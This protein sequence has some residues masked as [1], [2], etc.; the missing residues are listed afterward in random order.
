MRVQ[1]GLLLSAGLI[2]A[3]PVFA[4]KPDAGKFILQIQGTQIGTTT[5]KTDKEGGTTFDQDINLG[6][7]KA[8]VHAVITATGGKISKVTYEATPGGKYSLNV[9]GAKSTVS[10]NGAKEKP[11]KLADKIYLF[12]NFAPHVL[13]GLLRAY[14]SKKGG[15]QKLDC[16][17]LNNAVPMKVNVTS[18]GTKPR[19][20]GGKMVSTT[21]YVLSIAGGAGTVEI[22]VVI[23]SDFR[24]LMWNVVAQ[25]YKAWREGYQDLAKADEVN[26][27][28]LSKPTHKVTVERKVRV[29]MRDGVVLIADV[30][31]P[32]E[33]GKYP[34]ILQ[35]TP[36][37][38]GNAFEAN[39]Y[40]ER[41]YVFVAQDVRGKFDSQGVFEPF[42]N[43]AQ[44]GHDTVEWCGTQA[45][46][47]G[48]VGM[49]G[50]SYLGFVQWAAAREGSS[51]LKCLIPIVSPPDPFFN[52]P[53][54]FGAFFYYPS[55]WWAAI[56]KDKGMNAPRPLTNFD[57]FYTLPIKDTDKALF[58]KTIPFYQKWLQNATNNSYWEKVNF[59]ERM[60]SFKPLPA[61]HVSGWFDGDGIGTKRNYAFML[62]AGQK[63]Q[64][65]VYGPWPHAV[66]SVTQLG[67][68]NFGSDSL[69]DLDTLY[70][71]WF[72]R[73]LKGVENGVDKEPPVDA[74]LMGK[75]QWRKFSAWPPSEAKMQKWYLHS[76]GNA[77]GVKGDG[78]LSQ[79]SPSASEKPDRF[80]YD[81]AKP[82]VPH[83]FQADLKA[84]K[85]NS[86]L[87]ATADEQGA[88]RL[89]YTSEPLRTEVVVAGPLSLRL[90]AET[91]AKDTDWYAYISDVFPNGKSITLVQGIVRAR[92]RHS[93]VKPSLLKP[94]EVAQYDIDLWAL[95]HVFQ[96]GHRIRVLI[97]SS[98]F[99]VYDRNLNTGEEI[100]TA[101]RMVKANQTIYHQHSRESYLLLPV[102]PR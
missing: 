57:K 59:N 100:A 18:R 30:Y 93:F 14:D 74:F 12:D 87:D 60:K 24:V 38:R 37:G 99:P 67:E 11:F 95:G 34:V 10:V 66:N 55:L 25:K 40:A 13:S 80:V 88:D 32:K 77:N 72:D 54:A 51:Y 49:I 22:E 79:T 8:K 20:A 58:G 91:S 89:L 39:Y 21:N 29:P 7:N 35:R 15:A 44:D 6:G 50:G 3:L 70:L 53:Y 83:S 65:L 17:L 5:F 64:K 2:V 85:E 73:W 1:L 41:G 33:E 63:N 27:P 31:R 4:Q 96:K 81:P 52:I 101:T 90:T 68:L 82:F 71:R 84:G 46:S 61:L 42:V 16:L 86:T 26:D 36:Y 19:K 23:D 97:T 102:L 92:F 62:A 9:Q 45:W 56:V 43:E 76:G 69:R 47:D 75:N 28:L 48:N 98:C 94:G 78:T